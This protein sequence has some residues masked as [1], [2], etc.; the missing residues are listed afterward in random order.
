VQRLSTDVV[1]VGGGAAGLAAARLL[2][3]NGR[4]ATLLD[5]RDRL[6][7]RMFT[8]RVPGV[9]VP[10]ELGAEYIH[11]NP[12]ITLDLLREAGMT[13]VEVMHHRWERQNGALRDMG[14]AFDVARH[15]LDSAGRVESDV[16]VEE[17]L[18]RLR[19]QQ[20]LREG[21]R[22]FRE[23][24]EGF[25]AADPARASLKAIVEEWTGP[26][27]SDSTR[28]AG[29]YGPLVDVLTCDL[30][31]QQITV[32][33]QST[34]QIIEWKRGRVRVSGEGK[35]G[36]FSIDARCAIVTVPI[37][38]LPT[39][40]FQPEL[41]EKR[42]ALVSV[43]MG[44]VVKVVLQFRTRWWDE[45]G[46]AYRDGAF[47]HN[48]ETDFPT[49]WTQLPMRA[50][51]ITAW[52]GGP[53]A[54]RFENATESAIVE[55]ALRS[56]ASTFGVGSITERLE[57]AFVHDWGTDPFA[58]GAYS[59]VLVGG[60]GSRS[61]LA[62]PLDSTLFFAG[63][64]TSADASGTVSGALESGERAAREVLALSP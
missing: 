35:A 2:A 23:L 46:P 29:G 55:R 41:R 38:I 54:A 27:L 9:A 57:T 18:N 13:R 36:R 4:S 34:V 1:I 15:V 62:A 7:G 50:P 61:Q 30:N 63:E 64:A 53:N 33:L 28:P 24:V 59:Y 26:T 31:P 11:G 42:D 52:V 8:R 47:F 48:F 20:N 19:P 40:T 10:V 25:D 16:S 5:A 17:F 32:R 6:G 37:S 14:D 43:A 49:F 3:R 12:Q 60:S 51:L 56:L 58:R 44:H 22:W 39:L 45:L 21:I